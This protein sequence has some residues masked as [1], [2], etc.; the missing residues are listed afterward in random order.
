MKASIIKITAILLT[1]LI[2][3]CVPEKVYCQ[4][5]NAENLSVYLDKKELGKITVQLKPVRDDYVEIKCRYDNIRFYTKVRSYKFDE[6]DSLKIFLYSDVKNKKHVSI[7]DHIYV[8]YNLR[9]QWLTV[10]IKYYEPPSHLIVFYYPRDGGQDKDPN[11]P[12]N[13]VYWAN[14]FGV[15]K[16][17]ILQSERIYPDALKAYNREFLLGNN[18]ATKVLLDTLSHLSDDKNIKAFYFDVFHSI[19]YYAFYKSDEELKKILVKPCINILLSNR[20]Y[21]YNYL[22]CYVNNNFLEQFAQILGKGFY[23]KEKGL[24]DLEY[25]FVAFKRK[26]KKGKNKWME[27]PLEELFSEIE[28]VMKSLN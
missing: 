12:N 27:K 23:L 28:K 18:E 13:F 9:F 6:L 19:V 8:N 5:L 10:G 21:V 15:E 7:H 3:F 14:L 17:S 4:I 24:L 2:V 26:M 1:L 16:D 25:N 11:N 20:M 22:Y